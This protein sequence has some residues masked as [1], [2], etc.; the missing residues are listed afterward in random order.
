MPELAKHTR[1]FLVSEVKKDTVTD[2]LNYLKTFSER[3]KL[4]L[5]APIHLEEGRSMEDKLKALQQQGY[6]RVK[7]K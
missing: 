1:L 4:L 7:S 2:V 3:E 6:A 5:L